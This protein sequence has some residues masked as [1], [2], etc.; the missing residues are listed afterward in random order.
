MVNMDTFVKGPTEFWAGHSDPMLERAAVAVASAMKLPLESLRLE[1][2][3]TDSETFREK[4]VPKHTVRRCNAIH[5][6]SIALIR[7]P[8][9]ANQ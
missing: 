1:H 9:V 7:G 2:V 3:S 8:G 6:A 4:K 5:I